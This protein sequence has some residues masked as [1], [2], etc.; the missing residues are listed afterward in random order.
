MSGG[1]HHFGDD[2]TILGRSKRRRWAATDPTY[3]R[4]YGLEYCKGSNCWDLPYIITGSCTLDLLAIKV[5][6]AITEAFVEFILTPASFFDSQSV[7]KRASFQDIV[8][9]TSTLLDSPS[10]PDHDYCE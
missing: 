2:Y 8:S 6:F 9:S 1:G 4:L 3:S 7:N 5:S 10:R